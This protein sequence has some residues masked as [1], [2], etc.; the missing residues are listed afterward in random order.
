MPNVQQSI[1]STFKFQKS[2]RSNVKC[3]KS[4]RSN[5]K[6]PKSIRL[7][8]T[9]P[10]SGVPPVIFATATPFQKI[11][12]IFSTIWQYLSL[13]AHW[14]PWTVIWAHTWYCH[15]EHDKESEWSL[16]G[17]MVGRLIRN[18]CSVIS[19]WDIENLLQSF[20]GMFPVSGGNIFF[21]W[22]QTSGYQHTH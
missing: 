9:E 7:I 4:I 1:R 19:V 2:I 20:S 12:W 22:I 21:S 6:C 10:T 3:Q 14:F 8:L 15:F 17:G 5:V 18:S 13:S 11:Q 16:K